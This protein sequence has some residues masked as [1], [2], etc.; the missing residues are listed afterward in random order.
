MPN[1]SSNFVKIARDG[2][3]IGEYTLDSIPTLIR[4]GAVKTTDHYWMNGMQEWATIS[5]FSV[6]AIT[7]K[8][9]N[10]RIKFWLIFGLIVFLL[11]IIV[12]NTDGYK[13]GLK[14][15]AKHREEKWDADEER[16]EQDAQ[17][18]AYL[19]RKQRLR[20]SLRRNR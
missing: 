11:L 20:D 12:P 16:R 15:L 14:E 10:K 1:P 7:T 2:V 19:E 3:I 17:R 13:E 5:L 9:S 8:S 4:L 6:P 18:D